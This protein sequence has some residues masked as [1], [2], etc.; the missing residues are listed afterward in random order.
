MDM[1]RIICPNSRISRNIR[2]QGILNCFNDWVLAKEFIELV[3]LFGG[4]DYP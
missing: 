2:I 4:N 3:K 1:I